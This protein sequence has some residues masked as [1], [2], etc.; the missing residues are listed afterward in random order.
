MNTDLQLLAR[1]V[2]TRNLVNAKANEL[3]LE[4][5]KVLEPFIGKKVI[6]ATPCRSWTKQLAQAVC[7]QTSVRDFAGPIEGSFR[8]VWNFGVYSVYAE[9]D[10]IYRIDE[11]SVNYVKKEFCV[12]WLDGNCD[13]TV[14][15]SLPDLVSFRTD[16]TVEEIVERR[17][18]LTELQA[19]VRAVESELAEFS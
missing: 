17:A 3:Q 11:V 7:E 4:F 12:C 9:I 16:Y 10:T 5:R 15:T 19:K 18:K 14:L 6:K 2:A 1:K 8:L 13:R